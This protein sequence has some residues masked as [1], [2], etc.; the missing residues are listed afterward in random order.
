MSFAVNVTERVRAR[1]QAEALQAE[2]LAAAQR[3]A[4]EREAF[5]DVSS[6]P[7]P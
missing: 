2:V 6:K 5:H 4:Q 7:P 3:Q 1:Q